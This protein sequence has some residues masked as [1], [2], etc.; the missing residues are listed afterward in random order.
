MATRTENVVKFGCV[1]FEI[2]E[3]T[4]IQTEKGYTDIDTDML[5]TILCTIIGG[6]VITGSPESA[7]KSVKISR[8]CNQLS[9]A[10]SK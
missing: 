10:G 6:K 4:D 9:T 3:W 5:I 8:C 2:C 1:L 7:L